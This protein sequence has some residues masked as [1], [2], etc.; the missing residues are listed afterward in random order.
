VHICVYACYVVYIMPSTVISCPSPPPTTPWGTPHNTYS[1]HLY[2]LCIC[3][4]V[5]YDIG[6][7]YTCATTC[8]TPRIEL[9]LRVLRGP[10]LVQIW[11]KSGSGGPDPGSGGPDW[12]SS[13]RGPKMT[14]FLAPFW[15]GSS[16]AHLHMYQ[17]YGYARITHTSMGTWWLRGPK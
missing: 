4:H 13:W 7:Y 1:A 14:P 3:V 17:L 10:N 8:G 16:S 2:I 9:I 12:G 6:T 5:S 11:S 15:R